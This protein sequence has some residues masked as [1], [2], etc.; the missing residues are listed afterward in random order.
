[1]SVRAACFLGCCH[2]GNRWHPFLG[3]AVGVLP[4]PASSVEMPPLHACPHVDSS[5]PACCEV[6][7]RALVGSVSFFSCP[8]GCLHVQHR[9][10]LL[11]AVTAVAANSPKY[12]FTDVQFGVADGY[13]GMVVGTV[14]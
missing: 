10:Y 3:T 1:M 14:A 13:T 12:A 6:H 9:W 4:P 8:R 5:P 7:S 11:S 2:H